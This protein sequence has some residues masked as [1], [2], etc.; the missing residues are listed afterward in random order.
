VRKLTHVRNSEERKNRRNVV[1]DEEIAEMFRK[2]DQFKNEYFKLRAKALVSMLRLFGKRRKELCILKLDDVEVDSRYLTVT[3]TLLKKRKKVVFSRRATKKV[4]LTDPLTKPIIEYLNYLKGLNP[5]PVY[6][7]PRGRAIFNIYTLIPNEHLS[8]R[9]LFNILRSLSTRVWCHLFR[10]TAAAD[11]I[12]QDSSLMGAFK[13]M[14]RL[15]LS[16]FRTGYNYLR[17]FASDIIERETQSKVDI[18]KRS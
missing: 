18:V 11:V 10:E 8:D 17:R 14:T 3:F 2:A 6:F 1:T 12:R 15:D 9:Q 13:V 7:F 16:D 4:P 5:K